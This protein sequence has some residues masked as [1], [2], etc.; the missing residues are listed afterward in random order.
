MNRVALRLH[1]EKL[2]HRADL[3]ELRR[4]ALDLFHAFK[5]FDCFLLPRR[6]LLL[7]IPAESQVP[8]E[9]HVGI[10]VAPDF[11]QVRYEANLLFEILDRRNRYVR[12]NACGTPRLFAPRNSHRNSAASP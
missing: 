2:P 6:M 7:E 12:S 9:K 8:P 11:A 5:Q 3:H 4:V 10:N 1:L